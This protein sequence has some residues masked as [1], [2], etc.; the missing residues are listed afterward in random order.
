M[1]N[2]NSIHSDK[3]ARKNIS[4]IRFEKAILSVMLSEEK[5]IDEIALQCKPEFF[6]SGANRK[7]FNDIIKTYN[8]Y[9]TN[10]ITVIQSNSKCSFSYLS[11]IVGYI[12]SSENAKSYIKCLKEKYINKVLGISCKETLAKLK[13]ENVN[14]S[15]LLDKHERTIYNLLQENSSD[16]QDYLNMAECTTRVNTLLEKIKERKKAGYGFAGI[17]TGFEFLNKKFSGFEPG[18]LYVLGARPSTG[19]TSF[20]VQ[21]AFN[22][23]IINKVPGAIFSLEMPAEQITLRLLCQYHKNLNMADI[24]EGVVRSPDL[25]QE[26]IELLEQAP[27]YIDDN[28]GTKLIDIR[29]KMRRL[30]SKKK[31]EYVIV[32]YLQLVNVCNS[33]DRRFQI[34]EICKTLRNTGQELGLPV[35]LLAQL[36]RKVEERKDRK[37]I[38]SDL[39]DSGEIEQDSDIIMFLH[40]NPEDGWIDTNKK[41]FMTVAKNRNGSTGTMPYEFVGSN[42]S[43]KPIDSGGYEGFI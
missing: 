25:L 17:D 39:R 36:S 6:F 18:H 29:R 2:N 33:D 4:N 22:M 32:D 19:K 20:A 11:E 40:Q 9:K 23:S 43:F 1:N 35:I 8:E 15:E 13:S 5:M 12:C 30:A 41:I 26:G 14:A 10:E 24:K 37:P 27:L 42:M 3:H 38:L 21:L 34:G 7:L 31:I 28:S 16:L